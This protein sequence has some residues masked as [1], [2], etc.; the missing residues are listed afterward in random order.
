[1]LR[2]RILLNLLPQDGDAIEL[3]VLGWNE[4]LSTQFFKQIVGKT[5][6]L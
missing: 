2:T 5:A 1:M 3:K 6:E 4:W